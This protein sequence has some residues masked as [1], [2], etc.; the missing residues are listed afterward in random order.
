MR[1]I[2]LSVLSLLA[3]CRSVEQ[4][5]RDDGGKD[6]IICFV[7]NKMW[8][9]R[10]TGGRFWICDYGDKAY[11]MQVEQPARIFATAPA[12]AAPK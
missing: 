5:V 11:C 7:S 3:G 8:A 10:D 6:P 2:L 4:A 9:C 12:E 1:L